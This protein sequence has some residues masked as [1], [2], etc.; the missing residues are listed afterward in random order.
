[1]TAWAMEEKNKTDFYKI[2]TKFIPVE[3]KNPDGEEFITKNLIEIKFVNNENNND[4]N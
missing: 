4:N 1:M 2:I 3:I